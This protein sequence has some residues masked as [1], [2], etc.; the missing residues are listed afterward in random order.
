M[1]T[2]LS[3]G[4]DD[5]SAFLTDA[6]RHPLASRLVTL[7]LD[8]Y[9]RSS[10]YGMSGP[11][12]RSVLVKCEVAVPEAFEPEGAEAMEALGHVARALHKAGVA[13]V[14]W[15]K[16]WSTNVPHCLRMGPDELP[17]AE[18]LG[19][20]VGYSFLEE[21]LVKTIERIHELSIVSLDGGMDTPV[22]I[23]DFL[24]RVRS[25]LQAGDTAP[26]GIGR[27]AFKEQCGDLLDALQA[28][29]AIGRG[30]QG[31]ERVVSQRVFRDTKRLAALR[32]RVAQL[33]VR[34]DPRWE[35]R[36]F[37]DATDVLAE[38]GVRRQP[39]MLVFAGV[40]ELRFGKS[41]LRLEDMVPCATLP[42]TW[43]DA[44]AQ[45]LA[46]AAPAVVTTIEN[47]YAFLSYVEDAAGATG[48]CERGEVA[49]YTAGNPAPAL[50]QVLKAVRVAR[51]DTTIRHWGDAD[52]GGIEIWRY[53]RRALGEPLPLFR[54]SA[55]SLRQA[56]KLGSAIS[57]GERVA[58]M[59]LRRELADEFADAKP[60]AHQADLRSAI[61]LIEAMLELGIKV[62]Q[63]AC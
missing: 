23:S 52:V 11:W 24:E 63:E 16:G 55:L 1:S 53:L 6:V 54:T 32:S 5:R 9:E 8:A 14:E 26:L 27:E 12:R 61:E 57:P 47:F 37:G 20:L 21:C 18:A 41:L 28:A 36:T 44:L 22:W 29:V 35:S 3:H 60:D 38:Y 62:E 30:E 39:P 46:A 13:R 40:A 33:L 51:P 19:R 7:L 2:A 58:L 59:R 31:W 43:S 25:S 42:A 48:L 50:I 17:R 56:A 4:R 34:A 10:V 49:C 45:G 15:G